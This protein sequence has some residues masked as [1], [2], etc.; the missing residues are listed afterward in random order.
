MRSVG[1][2]D[3]LGSDPEADSDAAHRVH[4]DS[5]HGRDGEQQ[6][7]DRRQHET[8]LSAEKQGQE[9]RACAV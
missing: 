8:H 7:H 5:Q 2:A 4:D 9:L 1:A 3:W 6:E